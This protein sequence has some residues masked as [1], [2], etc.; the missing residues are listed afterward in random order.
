MNGKL[1]TLV[2]DI[3]KR[4]RLKLS[5]RLDQPVANF[6][7][8]MSLVRSRSRGRSLSSRIGADR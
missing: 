5:Q 6:V 1:W 2:F 3:G 8:D 7:S 4:R